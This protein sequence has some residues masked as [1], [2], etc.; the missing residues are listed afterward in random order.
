MATSHFISLILLCSTVSPSLGQTPSGAK[1]PQP[2]T[3]TQTPPDLKDMLQWMQNSLDP[4]TGNGSLTHHADPNDLDNYHAEQIEAFKFNGCSLEI[5]VGVRDHGGLLVAE[6]WDTTTDSFS[7]E[8]IDPSSIAIE[9]ACA[10]VADGWG[11]AMNCEDEQGKAVRFSTTNNVKKIH[12]NGVGWGR[13]DE[14]RREALGTEAVEKIEKENKFG[15]DTYTT[16][17]LFHDHAYAVRFMKALRHAVELCGG[18][19][20][21]F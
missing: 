14:K 9:D 20:S 13:V 19:P 3:K 6:T 11:P 1:Q 8:D 4:S 12:F 10:P 18:K 21:A 17:Y 16:D 7:L 5:S 15:Y 2:T